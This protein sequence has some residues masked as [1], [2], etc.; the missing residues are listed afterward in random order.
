MTAR[1]C[2]DDN[3]DI[4]D[5]ILRIWAINPKKNPTDDKKR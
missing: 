1:K 3:K 5:Y 2:G 4:G